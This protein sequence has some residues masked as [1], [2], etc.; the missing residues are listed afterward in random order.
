MGG[1][2]GAEGRSADLGGRLVGTL[3]VE[4]A[5][6]ASTAFNAPPGV[7]A[8]AG[9]I[10]AEVPGALETAVAEARSGRAARGRRW[11]T[12]AVLGMSGVHE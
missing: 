5:F 1:G 4:R 3:I 9:R 11:F 7:A 12:I 2:T 6:V 10:V 8:Q